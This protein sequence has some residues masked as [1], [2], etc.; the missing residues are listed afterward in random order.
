M[1]QLQLIEEL[2]DLKIGWCESYK[3][4]DE[5]LLEYVWEIAN[6]FVSY[7]GDISIAPAKFVN[8][9][10]TSKLTPEENVLRLKEMG[11]DKSLE[12]FMAPNFKKM[13]MS[14]KDKFLENKD[15]QNTIKAFGLDV[16]KLWYL[17]LFVHDYIEDF[18]TSLKKSEVQDIGDFVDSLSN[19][20]GITL[21]LTNEIPMR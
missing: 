5:P 11:V 7:E 17:L 13:D 21:T 8:R 15:L 18:S 1:E 9:Y 16:S 2:P 19:C 4:L 14:F 6:H 10:I 20:S 12:D 3:C